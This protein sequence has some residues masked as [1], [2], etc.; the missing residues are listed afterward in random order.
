LIIPSDVSVHARGEPIHRG[1]QAVVARF[2]PGGGLFPLS[3]DEGHPV[4]GRGFA[5][6]TCEDAIG[7]R[8]QAFVRRQRARCPITPVGRSVAFFSRP[9]S[10]L[11][12]GVTGVSHAEELHDV[13]VP[14]CGR[15]VS[16]VCLGITN[17]S[18]TIPLIG[19]TIALRRGQIS[20]FRCSRA[21][22][23]P[24]KSTACHAG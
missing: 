2:F 23:H 24:G 11:R 10:R 12:S 7:R 9:V 5:V 19:F 8:S 13:R 1:I 22:C 6:L 15:D 18:Q 14:D 17:V 20:F 4:A 3:A 16:R 21:T